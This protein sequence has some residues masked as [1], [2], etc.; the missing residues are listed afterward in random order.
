[1]YLS[2]KE[3]IVFYVYKEFNF[4]PT[5]QILFFYFIF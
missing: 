5:N 2:R 1:M 3:V 4:P